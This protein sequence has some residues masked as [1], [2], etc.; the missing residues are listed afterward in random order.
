MTA[1]NFDPN[2]IS[3]SRRSDKLLVL[4]L[5]FSTWIVPCETD[6]CSGRNS[7]NT[8]YI[9]FFWRKKKH[10]LINLTD[11]YL[12]FLHCCFFG[13]FL[14]ARMLRLIH[15]GHLESWGR[16]RGEER[17]EGKKEHDQ[18]QICHPWHGIQFSLETAAAIVP[19]VECRLTSNAQTE[20]SRNNR[21]IQHLQAS[22][23]CDLQGDLNRHDG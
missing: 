7:G 9:H 3:C 12:P 11:P 20:M 8:Q 14:V 13:A 18:H 2:R 1:P 19:C 15:G 23:P 4:C 6:F 22:W 10:N 17:G 21:D 16:G 5:Q